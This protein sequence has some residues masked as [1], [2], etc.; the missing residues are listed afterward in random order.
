[1]MTIEE[2]E[3]KYT[4]DESVESETFSNKDGYEGILET[5][6]NDLKIVN[7]ITAETPKRIWTMVEDEDGMKLVAGKH[8][9]NRI[10]YVI[11]NEE[12]KNEDE[13]YFV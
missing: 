4:S 2:W 1:M 8:L 6:G 11:S 7:K 13:E 3:K 10:Y 5:Y 12:W 9:V